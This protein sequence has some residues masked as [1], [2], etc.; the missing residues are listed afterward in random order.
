MPPKPASPAQV[1]A[2]AMGG[3]GAAT[4]P[5]PLAIVLG[6]SASPEVFP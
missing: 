3:S 6:G 2:G 5:A 4:P 1:D